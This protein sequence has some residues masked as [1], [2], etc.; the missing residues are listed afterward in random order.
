MITLKKFSKIL[1]KLQENMGVFLIFLM[2]LLLSAQVFSRYILKNPLGW[3]EELARFVFIWSIFVGAVI[4]AKDRQHIRVE[5]FQK[6]F[7]DSM[8]TSIEIFVNVSIVLFFIYII[9]PAFR[10]ALYAYHMKSVA[11]EISMFFVY[12]SLPLCSVFM[13]IYYIG[14]ITKDIHKLTKYYKSK[15]N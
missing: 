1:L 3:T 8:N 11:S 13:T 12:I 10:Y 14:H 9:P 4:A 7:S 5:T 15:Q 2:V 6:Y